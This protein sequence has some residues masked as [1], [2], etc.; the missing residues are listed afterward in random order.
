MV[1]RYGRLQPDGS[2]KRKRESKG[3]APAEKKSKTAAQPDSA[4]LAA[5]KE[6]GRAAGVLKY[7]LSQDGFRSMLTN[8]LSNGNDQP[9]NVQNAKGC[10][11][12]YR[13]RRLSA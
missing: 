3:V 6:L 10:G 1:L 5:L 2:S 4:G 13:G 12:K 7:V 9:T 11:I 8:S